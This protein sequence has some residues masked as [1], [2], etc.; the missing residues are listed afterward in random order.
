MEYDE[1]KIQ[2]DIEWYLDKICEKYNI[3]I[4]YKWDFKEKRGE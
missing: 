2:S 3:Y 1:E 4:E